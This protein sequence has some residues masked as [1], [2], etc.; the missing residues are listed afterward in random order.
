[1]KDMDAAS[2]K[3]RIADLDAYEERVFETLR[4]RDLEAWKVSPV[5]GKKV[6]VAWALLHAYQHTAVHVGHIEILVQQWKMSQGAKP[7]TPPLPLP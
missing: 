7:V 5:N 6:T 2:L 3:K 4:V 1:V